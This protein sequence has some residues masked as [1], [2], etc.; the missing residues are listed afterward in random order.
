MLSLA[1][2]IIHSELSNMFQIRNELIHNL[3]HGNEE[4]N[5]VRP[6]T[7]VILH[8]GQNKLQFG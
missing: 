3:F 6:G 7:N 2:N 8:M 5:T 1:R 4:K